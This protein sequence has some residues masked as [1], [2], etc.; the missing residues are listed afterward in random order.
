MKSLANDDA[1]PLGVVSEKINTYEFWKN[2]DL[3]FRFDW[4]TKLKGYFEP[5]GNM[6]FCWT[7]SVK[8][9]ALCVSGFFLASTFMGSAPH[10]Q[11]IV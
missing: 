8:K 2:R 6:L 1:K 3:V 10:K 4:P 11:A 9:Y 5:S 7:I